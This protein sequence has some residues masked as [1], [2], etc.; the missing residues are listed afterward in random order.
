M[1]TSSRIMGKVFENVGL[2]QH[3]LP[4]SSSSSSS[5]TLQPLSAVHST[6]ISG[7]PALKHLVGITT[8]NA[9]CWWTVSACFGALAIIF[10]EFHS[11]QTLS[12][13]TVTSCSTVNTSYILPPSAYPPDISNGTVTVS[14]L[15]YCGDLGL[16]HCQSG[17]NIQTSPSSVYSSALFIYLI[18]VAFFWVRIMVILSCQI[19]RA[20]A[21]LPHRIYAVVNAD[22]RAFLL[23]VVLLSTGYCIVKALVFGTM[24][25]TVTLDSCGP[26]YSEGL[27]LTLAPVFS[28]TIVVSIPP[29]NHSASQ[30]TV[31]NDSFWNT[32]WAL[33]NSTLLLLLSFQGVYTLASRYANDCFGD[34]GLYNI[35]YCPSS[36]QGGSCASKGKKAPTNNRNTTVGTNESSS[37][38]LESIIKDENHCDHHS[39]QSG[40]IGVGGEMTPSGKH[41]IPSARYIGENGI[42]NALTLPI[43]SI[44][45]RHLDTALKQWY[46]NRQKSGTNTLMTNE[47]KPKYLY[48]KDARYLL[49]CSEETVYDAAVFIQQWI[50]SSAA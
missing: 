46:D 43:L 10:N 9:V 31:S 47:K 17:T 18:L 2:T 27:V 5:S 16:F 39:C 28:S 24:S 45:S 26:R 49:K 50:K 4:S 34:I 25:S 29:G 48:W 3:L 20:T 14:P 8:G 42:I 15:A 44:D 13:R 1:A 12:T 40:S 22:N 32:L 23:S 7:D 37:N 19:L 38:L 21:L 33:A 36:G 30:I 35:L 41:G 6:P 11:W